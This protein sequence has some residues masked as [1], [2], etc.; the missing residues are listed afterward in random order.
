[1]AF[2]LTPESTFLLGV[3]V[4]WAILYGLAYVLH[5]DKHGLEVKPAYFMYRSKAL[6]SFLDRLA[7]RWR[8]FW[9]VLSNIGL[10]FSI[11]LM[12]FSIYFLANNLLRFIFPIGPV[13]PV[14]P[15]VPVLFIRLY[16]MPYFFLAV[17][18]IFF[19]HE[20]THGIISKVEEIP[21]LSTGIYAVLVFFGAFVEPDEKEFEKSPLLAKL[22]MLAT[23]SS[24]NLLTGLLVILLMGGLFAPPS[25]VLIHEVTPNGPL[26]KAY[27]SIQQWDVIQ[28][29]N[30]T[31]IRT[32][33]EFAEY[34]EP[35]N[36]NVTLIV[37]ILNSDTLR[38]ITIITGSNE[39]GKG[40]V[41][42][43]YSWASYQ[44]SRIGLGQYININ[45]FWSLF[46][47]YLLGVSVAI[48]NMLP[49]FPFDGE[50][51]LYYSLASK[52]KKRKRE[53]RLALNIFGWGLFVLNGI[54]SFL[55]FGF[56]RF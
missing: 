35:V 10:A 29:L 42:I 47:I 9:L 39:K 17:G 22:R 36:P 2:T 31:P 16:W 3:A 19:T 50:K 23:S 15:A 12:V 5:L 40:T 33:S 37:T 20:L 56:I 43:M 51:V 44:P 53:L 11:G 28:A 45:L 32:Y 48:F 6:N 14:L 54:L 41:G 24:V 30:G 7:K 1:M 25:G 52:V 38:N 8:T 34:M 21:L 49:A 27:P 18:I 13:T 55:I 26:V 4:F 46:W